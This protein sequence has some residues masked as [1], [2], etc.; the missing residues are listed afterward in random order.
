MDL[1]KKKKVT[2]R[3]Q[4]DESSISAYPS[5]KMDPPD[6]STILYNVSINEDFPA[7]VLRAGKRS[8]QS[9]IAHD[10]L[11]TT[12]ILSP[13]WMDTDTPLSTFGRPGR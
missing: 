6:N 12:P 10:Y 7:P 1:K 4:Y 11:P 8:D 2:K 13:P 9:P 5:R 3:V